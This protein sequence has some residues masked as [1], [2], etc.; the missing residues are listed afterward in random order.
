MAFL[1]RQ[2][3]R[4]SAR[5]NISAQIGMYD[6]IR[7]GGG[8]DHHGNMLRPDPNVK[9]SKIPDAKAHT[10]TSSA[11]SKAGSTAGS[12]AAVGH[13]HP[14]LSKKSFANQAWATKHNR[15]SS[16]ESRA[17]GSPK[18]RERRR[19]NAEKFARDLKTEIEKGR[20]LMAQVVNG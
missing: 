9:A 19:Q 8:F 2:A 7:A 17:D 15:N 11:L 3:A 4:K 14:A 5:T 13:R 20:Q 12:A 1:N 6:N 16:G 10:A 18:T